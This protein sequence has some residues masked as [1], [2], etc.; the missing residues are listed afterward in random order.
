M[1]QESRAFAVLPKDQNL[2]A[3][4]RVKQLTTASNASSRES[5]TGF[6]LDSL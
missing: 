2:V 6:A 1:A 5:D 4:T 3:S